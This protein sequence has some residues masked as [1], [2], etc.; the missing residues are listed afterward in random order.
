MGSPQGLNCM[1][2]NLMWLIW[3]FSGDCSL[4][5]ASSVRGITRTQREVGMMNT[6]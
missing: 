4:E 1:N 6:G 3:P 5:S 2:L